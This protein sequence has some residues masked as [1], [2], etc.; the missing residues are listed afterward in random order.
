M[1]QRF[2]RFERS[3]EV[4][5]DLVAGWN[6][7]FS[8]N[9]VKTENPSIAVEQVEPSRSENSVLWLFK[10]RVRNATEIP[11]S[12]LSVRVPHGKFRAE[13]RKFGP[14]VKIPAQDHFIVDQAVACQE[15]PNTVV[16]NAFLILLVNWQGNDWRVFVRL[17]ITVDQQGRPQTTTESITVQ[18][19]GFSGV[20]D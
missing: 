10:W 13:E 18:R 11:M 1:S 19:V 4:G 6:R 14:A 2:K 3:T 9:D 8:F 5:Q 16:E 20:S 7:S 17:R 15:P 12:L